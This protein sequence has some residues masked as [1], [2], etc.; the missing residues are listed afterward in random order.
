[1]SQIT[2]HILNTF[3]GK[4]AEGVAVTLLQYEHGDWHQVAI[5]M[6]DSDGRISDLLDE[7]VRLSGIFKLNFDSGAYF[8]DRKIDSFYPFIEITFLIADAAEHYHVPLLLNPYGY[9]TYRGS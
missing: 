2:T 7:T 9:T 4:P 1:M 8:A 3:A 5:G 6:T